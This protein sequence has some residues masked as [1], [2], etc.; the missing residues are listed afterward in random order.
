MYSQ[1]EVMKLS[2]KLNG[3]IV[4]QRRTIFLNYSTGLIRVCTHVWKYDTVECSVSLPRCVL[5]WSLIMAF[6]GQTR[7]FSSI[8][9]DTC[10][11]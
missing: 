11:T 4:K 6:P 10:I 8:T 3:F 7:F 5:G 9:G 2:R 1:I